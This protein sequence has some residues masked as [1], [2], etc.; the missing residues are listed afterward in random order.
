MWRAVAMLS[1]LVCAFALA[2]APF[3][4]SVTVEV[5]N[6]DVVALD[7]NGVAVGGLRAEDFELR[8]NGQP[9]AITNFSAYDEAAGT[10]L[11]L[12]STPSA[13]AAT[14]PAATP[15]A[16]ARRPARP[17]RASTSTCA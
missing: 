9:V 1:A 8:V 6:V 7:R 11:A 15:S 5:M 4:E 12:E 10:E 14:A 13:A 17:A 16:S 3:S 2:Q